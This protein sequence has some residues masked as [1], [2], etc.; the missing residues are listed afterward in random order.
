MNSSNKF[1]GN[2][3]RISLVESL[4]KNNGVEYEIHEDYFEMFVINQQEL[5]HK[6]DMYFKGKMYSYDICDNLLY[7]KV[8]KYVLFIQ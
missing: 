5:K 8:G 4:C 6:K 2:K 7:I 1:Y 3:E